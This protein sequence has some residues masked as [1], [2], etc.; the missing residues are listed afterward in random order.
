MKGVPGN[1]ALPGEASGQPQASVHRQGGQGSL[2]EGRER[3][4]ATL[5]GPGASAGSSP[6]RSGWPRKRKPLLQWIQ[7]TPR[8]LGFRLRSG[9]GA[10]PRRGGWAGRGQPPAS[11][12]PALDQRAEPA[13]WP[14]Y[15]DPEQPCGAGTHFIVNASQIFSLVR[16]TPWRICSIIHG[17]P[18][19]WPGTSRVSQSLLSCVPSAPGLF[20]ETTRSEDPTVSPAPRRQIKGPCAPV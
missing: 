17:C 12:S 16:K 6:G 5:M 15:K 20:S 4:G 1:C 19:G 2:E 14:G 10:S 7:Q 11:P 13:V 9:G 3:A 8:G 18:G